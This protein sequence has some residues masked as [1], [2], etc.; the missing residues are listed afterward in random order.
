MRCK[1]S[2]FSSKQVKCLPRVDSGRQTEKGGKTLVTLS[3]VQRFS[4]HC[5]VDHFIADRVCLE[6]LAI[7]QM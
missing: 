4:S 5:L 2:R 1:Y 6:P 3:A 7:L